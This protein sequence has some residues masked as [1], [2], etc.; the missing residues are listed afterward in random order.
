MSDEKLVRIEE[1]HNPNFTINI[2]GD[3]LSKG[4]NPEPLV[5]LVSQLTQPANAATPSEPTQNSPLSNAGDG[6]TAE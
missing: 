2:I 6:Q 5:Q 1:A 3:I 4:H